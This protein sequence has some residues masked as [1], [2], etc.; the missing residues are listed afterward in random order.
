MIVIDI[1]EATLA[2]NSEFVEPGALLSGGLHLISI[3]PA[4][5]GAECR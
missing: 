3:L 1:L 4:Q 5:D 2:V